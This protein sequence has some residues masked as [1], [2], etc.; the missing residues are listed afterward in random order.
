MRHSRAAGWPFF[1]PAALYFGAFLLLPVIAVG[2]L[3][4]TTWSG[5]NTSTIQWAGLA[6]YERLLRDKF[7]LQA[8]W[9]TV[10]FTFATTIG[11]N[12]L[13]FAL[14]MLIHTRVRGHDLL[15]IAIL[16]PIGVSPVVAGLIWQQML[17]PLGLAN[18]VVEALGGTPVA[19]LGPDL[20]FATVIVVSIWMFTGYNTILYYAGLQSLPTER[21]DAAAIDGAG[22]LATIRHVVIPYMRPVIA[23]VVVLNLIGG[24]KVFDIVFVLTR[25]GPFRRTEMLS[26]YLY[27]QAFNRSDVGF[28]SAIAVLIVLLA[29]ISTLVRGRLHGSG[30]V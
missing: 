4:L 19:F 9:H 1:G 18:Q 13:G 24:W 3:S 10:I 17:G 20:A 30:D 28:A 16:L 12:V 6:N 15:R 26:T 7:L 27:E 25:G 5:F 29:T 22:H 2:V 14:A 11:L 21:L 23:V 8:L